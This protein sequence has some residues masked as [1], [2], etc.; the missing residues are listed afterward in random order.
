[1][2]SLNHSTKRKTGSSGIIVITTE[3]MSHRHLLIVDIGKEGLKLITNKFDEI[4]LQD[5]NTSAYMALKE[6]Y[7]NERDIGVIIN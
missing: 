5:L 3:H 1:M 4:Y 6:F 2:D 7:F